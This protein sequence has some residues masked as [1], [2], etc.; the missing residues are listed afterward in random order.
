LT[1]QSYFI[2]RNP[3]KP[4]IGENNNEGR[5]KDKDGNIKKGNKWQK[6]PSVITL[7]GAR[8]QSKDTFKVK[9]LDKKTTPTPQKVSPSV[10][11][12][13][14]PKNVELDAVVFG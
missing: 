2:F 3:I 12:T 10:T 1:Q 14:T 6:F 11:R 7:L 4:R 8:P 5:F 13:T 9:T